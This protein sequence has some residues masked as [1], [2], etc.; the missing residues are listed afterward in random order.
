MRVLNLNCPWQKEIAIEY[1]SSLEFDSFL[2]Q[3]KF[4]PER[5]PA[6]SGVEKAFPTAPRFLPALLTP[7]VEPRPRLT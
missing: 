7:S 6:K 5:V 4:W 1:A 2:V 3:G